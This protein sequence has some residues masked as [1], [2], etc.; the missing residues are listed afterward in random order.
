[1]KLFD[2]L[3]DEFSGG[4]GV[5]L[6]SSFE[7]GSDVSESSEVPLVVG[8]C[9]VYAESFH[10]G[11]VDGVVEV[12]AVGGHEVRPYDEVVGVEGFDVQG[13]VAEYLLK[14]G[15]DVSLS[16]HGF[17]DPSDLAEHECGGRG[18]FAFLDSPEDAC[19]CW[20]ESGVV[21]GD[22]YED[23]CVYEPHG[24]SLLSA[25][26]R[27]CLRASSLGSS[28]GS[29]VGRLPARASVGLA[30]LFTG[31]RT[32]SPFRSLTMTRVFS[33]ISFLS[34]MFFGRTIRPSLPTSTNIVTLSNRLFSVVNK[35]DRV[36]WIK[37]SNY[38]VV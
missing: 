3:L 4:I 13:G 20:S 12:E 34:R 2:G 26:S 24:S 37:S 35:L 22:V 32:I 23:V 9:L 19:G 30:Y 14:G 21:C 25:F 16:A 10:E 15:F 17:E 1:M 38:G 5:L 6:G 29:S 8:V 11:D 33:S 31:M 7:D 28:M 36:F 27:V 18:F